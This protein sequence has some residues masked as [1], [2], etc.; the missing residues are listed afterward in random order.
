MLQVPSKCPT[1]LMHAASAQQHIICFNKHLVLLRSGWGRQSSRS[2]Y[3]QT[4]KSSVGEMQG[5]VI[6]LLLLLL[7]VFSRS[8]NEKSHTSKRLVG[9]LTLVSGSIWN[10]AP[11]LPAKEKVSFCVSRRKT[12]L[13]QASTSW[14]S[15]MKCIR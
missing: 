1:R 14:N 7:N 15:A 11:V 8:P 3:P 10:S 4:S 5:N 13:W 2:H 12:I 9:S 6:L